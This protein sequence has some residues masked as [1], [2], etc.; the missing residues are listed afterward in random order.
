M[1]SPFKQ[2]ALLWHNLFC[3][4]YNNWLIIFPLI[5]AVQTFTGASRVVQCTQTHSGNAWWES[6][7]ISPSYSMHF[8]LNE[9][10]VGKDIHKLLAII[11]THANRKQLSKIF[12]WLVVLCIVTYGAAVKLCYCRIQFLTIKTPGWCKIQNLWTTSVSI[13]GKYVNYCALQ[14]FN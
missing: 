12:K 5:Q 3:F 10:S 11:I 7:N 13:I 2:W 14:S 4:Q 8:G 6:D 1:T 9:D